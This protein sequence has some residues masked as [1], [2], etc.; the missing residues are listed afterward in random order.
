MAT[1][2]FAQESKTLDTLTILSDKLM[3][4]EPLV[5]GENNESVLCLLENILRDRS[6]LAFHA[7][8]SDPPPGS[9]DHHGE[10]VSA[11]M[12]GMRVFATITNVSRKSSTR[13]HSLA[14]PM[15]AL[16]PHNIRWG[17]LLHPVDNGAISH[18]MRTNPSHKVYSGILQSYQTMM[19]DETNIKPFLHSTP[20]VIVQVFE[21]WLRFPRYIPSHAYDASPAAAAAIHMILSLRRSLIDPGYQ[22]TVE[23]RTLFVGTLRRVLGSRRALY[24]A[25]AQHTEFLAGLDPDIGM[26]HA[27]PPI[28]TIWTDHY[29]LFITLID[30][31]KFQRSNI[32]TKTITSIVSAG[33]VCLAR[34]DTR[35]GA[36]DAFRVLHSLCS[37]AKSN[38]SLV[39]ALDAGVFDLLRSLSQEERESA[40]D[41]TVSDFVRLLCAGLYHAQVIRALRHADAPF[42]DLITGAC[43]FARART[44]STA[45]GAASEC[46]GPYILTR[47]AATTGPG[48][49]A[50]RIISLADALF[51]CIAV[52]AYIDRHAATIERDLSSLRIK[53]PS[54]CTKLVKQAIIRVDI[55]DVLPDARHEVDARTVYMSDAP[56]GE[57]IPVTVEVVL[58][59][60]KTSVTRFLPFSHPRDI[61]K[62]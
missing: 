28:P 61:F 54:R 52:R 3:G 45:L 57:S 43:R 24:N 49:C 55:T 15:R 37:M 62:H 5:P 38:R 6:S 44:P 51:I 50:V 40:E 12:F 32:P 10:L 9:L 29:D 27:I 4:L 23:D 11:V 30:M 48:D 18:F 56:Q 21:L 25:F 17:A 19:S 8:K 2:P 7:L 36:I 13:Y 34:Q 47:A 1:S 22:P 20:A 16:W 33:N 14:S 31:P 26:D 58:R 53:Q 46:I 35:Y 42:R 60:G 39:D 41:H 59:V